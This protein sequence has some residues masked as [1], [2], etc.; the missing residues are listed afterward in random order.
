MMA[1]LLF[2]WLVSDKREEA[3]EMRTSGIGLSGL[4]GLSTPPSIFKTSSL[5][6]RARA[7]VVLSTPVLTARL[8][9]VD[10]SPCLLMLRRLEPQL[11][12]SSRVLAGPLELSLS[13]CS[14]P[15]KGATVGLTAFDWG[16]LPIL[17]I[18]CALEVPVLRLCSVASDGGLVVCGGDWRSAGM[19]VGETGDVPVDMAG[20]IS[21]EAGPSKVCLASKGDFASKGDLASKGD[22]ASKGDLMDELSPL[23]REGIDILALLLLEL[24]GIGLFGFLDA[25]SWVLVE[26]SVSW[27]EDFPATPTTSLIRL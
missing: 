16:V 3:E 1:G 15:M 4:M 24:L 22:F 14:F 25:A 17:G 18:V 10:P 7:A 21:S 27:T 11:E 19:V 8:G 6:L 12:G 2:T 13:R 23:G 20:G 26:L 9:G 5:L